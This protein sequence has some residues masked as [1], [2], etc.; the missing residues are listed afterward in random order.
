MDSSAWQRKR[1]ILLIYE[2]FARYEDKSRPKDECVLIQIFFSL[3]R[4]LSRLEFKLG[5]KRYDFHFFLE[6]FTMVLFSGV[7]MAKFDCD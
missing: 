6:E 1:I 5:F 3:L 4:S 7:S 2:E